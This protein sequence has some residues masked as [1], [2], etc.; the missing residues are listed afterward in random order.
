MINLNL[1]LNLNFKKL[2]RHID[3]LSLIFS[4]IYF[5]LLGVHNSFGLYIYLQSIPIFFGYSWFYNFKSSVFLF[6]TFL[7]FCFFPIVSIYIQE[8]DLIYLFL[9]FSIMN[10]ICIIVFLDSPIEQE[11][12]VYYHI[13]DTSVFYTKNISEEMCPVCLETNTNAVLG[14]GHR[15]HAN[16]TCLRWT[17][18]YG[19]CPV[20]R[21][22][23]LNA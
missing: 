13:I 7:N 19:M 23:I 20:C 18:V 1:N 8:K 22:P 16:Y 17:V 9:P 5:C 6:Q 21:T 10:M 14:C 15:L 4:T 3:P 2:T 12:P 11:L